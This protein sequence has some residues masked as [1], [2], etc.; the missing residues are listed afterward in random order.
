MKFRNILALLMGVI[1]VISLC[2]CGVDGVPVT[3]EPEKVVVLTEV[4]E[5][6][7]AEFGF[8]DEMKAIEDTDSLELFYQIS[9]DDVKQFAAETTRNSAEDITEI[10]LVEA[11]D[12]EAALR[13]YDALMVR[14]NSQR[15]LCASYSAELLAVVNECSVERENNFVT[16]IMSDK[17]DEITELYKS[18]F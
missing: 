10:I 6:I 9:P 11:V 13:V 8:A 18:F 3:D 1:M 7:N 17:D 4:L 16:L 5:A 12:E 2:A 14:Y 15:D